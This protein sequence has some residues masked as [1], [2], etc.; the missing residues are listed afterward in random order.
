MNYSK[1]SENDKFIVLTEPGI[2]HQMRLTDPLKTYIEVPGL[3]GCS[4]NECPYMKLNTLEK[5]LNCI[6]H[7][8]PSI[9]LE[10]KIIKKAYTPLKRMLDMSL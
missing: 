7:K 4:C 2:I 8:N 3:D 9:E 1:D 5:I 6:K 10:S